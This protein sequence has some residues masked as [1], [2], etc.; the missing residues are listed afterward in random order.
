MHGK[1]ATKRHPVHSPASAGARTAVLRPALAVTAF[2]LLHSAAAASPL[3]RAVGARLGDRRAAGTERVLYVAQ[4]ALSTGLLGLDLLRLPDRPLYRVSG[5]PR[6]A[7]QAGQWLALLG[8]GGVAV[9][10]GPRRFLGLPQLFDLVA[11]R[12]LREG[13]VA[14]HPLPAGEEL[15]WS[16]P[17]RLSRHPNNYF[18]LLAWWLSPT[19]TQKWATVGVAAG[20]YMLLGSLHEE[21]RL[22]A[23]YGDRYRRYRAEVPHALGPPRR[24]P[25]EG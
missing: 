8:V 23:T 6:R 3:R 14:Q 17:Y 25:V 4:A 15:G 18:P 10:V 7:M 19:M 24:R 13:V 16:G 12:P 21:R 2:A 20:V 5:R 11:G 22:L 9:A 1:S